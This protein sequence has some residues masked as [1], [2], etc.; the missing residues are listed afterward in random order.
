MLPA[1]R[2]VTPQEV[3]DHFSAS[4]RTIYR[5]IEDGTL[6]AVRLRSGDRPMY[7]ILRSAVEDLELEAN[8]AAR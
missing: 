3:A 2:Y 6:P 8:S 5:M 4:V 7:R 1:T